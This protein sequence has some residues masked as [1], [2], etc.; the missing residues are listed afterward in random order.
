[1]ELEQLNLKLENR[2]AVKE[3]REAREKKRALRKASRSSSGGSS[4]GSYLST[5]TSIVKG[6]RLRSGGHSLEE[7]SGL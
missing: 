1:M 5:S 2:R 4:T 6:S 7:V 3:A